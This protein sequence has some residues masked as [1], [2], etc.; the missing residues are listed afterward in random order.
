MLFKEKVTYFFILLCIFTN[1]YYLLDETEIKNID[2][3]SDTNS[4]YLYCLHFA[5]ITQTTVG[6]G[7]MYPNSERGRMLVNIHCLLTAYIFLA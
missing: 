7:H 3:L 4:N 2:E 5:I 6:Y 1:L